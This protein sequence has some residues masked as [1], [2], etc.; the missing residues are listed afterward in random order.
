MNNL[1]YRFAEIT[2]AVTPSRKSTR[3]S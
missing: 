3:S 2:T 1:A